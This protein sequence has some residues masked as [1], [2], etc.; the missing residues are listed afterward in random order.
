MPAQILVA[1]EGVAHETHASV[2]F[3]EPAPAVLARVGSSRDGLSSQEA[4]RRLRELGPNQPRKP[5]LAGSTADLVR[6]AANPLVIIL[7]VAA[8]FSA[9]LG[10]VVDAAIITAMVFASIG[11]NTWQTL[12]SDHAVKRLQAQIAPTA[13]VL[14]D[15]RWVDVHRVEVVIGD[16]IRL[17]AGDLV[18]ADAVCSMRT[19]STF[20]RQR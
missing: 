10:Q 4:A 6:A 1:P 19:T 17:S 15:G 3:D 11:I 20:N 2:A 8:T 13:T 7:L 12:R 14:R 9:F 18:P 5:R 16:V